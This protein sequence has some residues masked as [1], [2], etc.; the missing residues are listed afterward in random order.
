MHISEKWFYKK[1]GIICGPLS[2][3]EILAGISAEEISAD[4][5][6][7]KQSIDEWVNYDAA[8]KAIRSRSKPK[9]SSPSYAKW[10]SAARQQINLVLQ[11][12]TVLRGITTRSLEYHQYAFASLLVLYFI[13][14]GRD[15]KLYELI[16]MDARIFL[17]LLIV[18]INAMYCAFTI[19]F[20]VWLTRE[21]QR[22]I[23]LGGSIRTSPRWAVGWFFVPILSLYKSVRILMDIWKFYAIANGHRT[24]FGY[25]YLSLWSLFSWLATPLLIITTAAVGWQ[26]YVIAAG[27]SGMSQWRFNNFLIWVGIQFFLQLLSTLLFSDVLR[28]MANEKCLPE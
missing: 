2:T 25:I 6:F 4:A 5:L 10:L 14:L 13:N 9:A 22:I 24:R 8:L 19:L 27:G 21:V 17:S 1:Q 3:D 18:F 28:R 12:M 20:F 15:N 23:D 26:L 11:E 16:N 7:W